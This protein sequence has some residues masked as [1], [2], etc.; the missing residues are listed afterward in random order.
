MQKIIYMNWKKVYVIIISA[1]FCGVVY[2]NK[3]IYSLV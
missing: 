2:I 3:V 1:S